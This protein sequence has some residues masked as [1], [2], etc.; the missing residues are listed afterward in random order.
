MSRFKPI[1]MRDLA[2]ER[3][4]LRWAQGQPEFDLY[5]SAETKKEMIKAR[6]L[7]LQRFIDSSPHVFERKDM[8]NAILQYTCGEYREL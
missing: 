8:Y 4:A 2:A 7:L 5:C 1:G 3:E 6:L